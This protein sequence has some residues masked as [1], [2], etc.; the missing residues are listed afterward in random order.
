MQHRILVYFFSFSV[1]L[2]ACTHSPPERPT[3]KKSVKAP[4]Q[5]AKTKVGKASTQPNLNTDSIAT[6]IDGYFTKIHKEKRFNGT[7]LIARHGKI[8]YKK[9]LGYANF[10]TRDSLKINSSFQLASVSKQFTAVAIMLLVEKGLI[11][12]EDTVQRFFP[13]FP[14]SGI[15]VRMLLNHRSGLCN[16]A[17]FCDRFYRKGGPQPLTNTEVLNLMS[18][19]K[20]KTY[21]PPNRRFDYSNTGYIILAAIVEKVS[22]QSFPDFIRKNI[23]IPLKMNNSFIALP[24]TIIKVAGHSSPGRRVVKDYLDEIYGDKGVYSSVED[25]YRWTEAL[26]NHKLLKPE[27]LE[28]AFSAGNSEQ[29]APFNYGFGWRIFT[30][31]N[32][33]K[34]IFHAGWWKGFKT[35]YLCRLQD[36]TTVI[37]LSNVANR[38]YK[39]IDELMDI[40][41]ARQRTTNSK[42]YQKILHTPE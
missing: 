19:H 31:K 42:F 7:V 24:D 1:L 16:Y 33:S 4:Q 38:S 20:P 10:R 41:Y 25:M 5:K 15:T 39:D 17:Y 36:K 27:T 34:T 21:L 29:K 11:N 28:Q 12:Y 3:A 35:F 13:N 9:A 6:A 23:F 37:I 18:N 30:A 14:Y 26:L 32:G 40:V 22:K 8:L 2:T